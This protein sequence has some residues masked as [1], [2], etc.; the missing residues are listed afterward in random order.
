MKTN[1]SIANLA[2]TYRTASRR[3]IPAD[4]R[5]PLASPA[6]AWEQVCLVTTAPAGAAF[7]RLEF[8]LPWPSSASLWVDDV[9]VEPARRGAAPGAG[10]SARSRNSPGTRGSRRAGYSSTR[11]IARPGLCDGGDDGAERP[12]RRSSPRGRRRRLD[13]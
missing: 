9:S 10:R 6:N 4:P 5:E 3:P 7:M 11:M 8:R 1:A 12:V 2:V 13:G